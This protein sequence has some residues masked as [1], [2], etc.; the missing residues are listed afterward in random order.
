MGRTDNRRRD[1]KW[2][3]SEF[4]EDDHKDW[5]TDIKIVLKRL[6]RATEYYL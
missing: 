6:L 2:I 5:K 4:H 1:E 3:E